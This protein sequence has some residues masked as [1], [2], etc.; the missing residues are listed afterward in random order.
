VIKQYS[1]EKYCNL[2]FYFKLEFPFTI[3]YF[4]IIKK[5]LLLLVFLDFKFHWHWGHVKTFRLQ[6]KERLQIP[7]CETFQTR[8]STWLEPPIFRKLAWY[9]HHIQKIQRHDGIF[10]IAVKERWCEV[11]DLIPTLSLL[12]IKYCNCLTLIFL[13]IFQYHF[14]FQSHENFYTWC[15]KLKKN[16][17]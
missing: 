12:W 4:V 14:L 5:G 8:A 17:F 3:M 11:D 9:I 13:Y 7:L 16:Y 6:C 2:E 15:L 1:S 10:I